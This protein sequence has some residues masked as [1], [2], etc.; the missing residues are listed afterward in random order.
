LVE[1]MTATITSVA[2][3][4]V[5]AVSVRVAGALPADPEVSV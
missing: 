2:A 5:G 4:P 1:L 3:M